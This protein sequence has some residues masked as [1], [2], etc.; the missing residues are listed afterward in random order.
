ML[1]QVPQSSTNKNNLITSILLATFLTGTLDG[2]AAVINTYLK[3]G[4]GP[5][6]V[7]KFI[8][9][10]VIGSNAFSGGVVILIIGILFHYLIAFIWTL[11]YFL[12][13]PKLKI[14]AS[15]KIISGIIYGVLIWLVMNLI[16]LPISNTPPIKFQ[17]WNTVLG[18]SYIM[19][20]VGLPI[21][22]IYHKY[23]LKNNR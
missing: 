18:I 17:F 13:Y 12:V 7:F 11:L 16:V 1:T 19:F 20:L 8:A 21:S 2:L 15:H 14:S 10:G 9:S 23:L 5:D 4:R 22:I 6:L 3:T